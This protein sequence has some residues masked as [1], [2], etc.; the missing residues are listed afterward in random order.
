MQCEINN[1]MCTHD[2]DHETYGN[3]FVKCVLK[4]CQI[5]NGVYTHD[6]D[7]ETHGSEFVKYTVLSNRY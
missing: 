7:Y 2:I 6:L 3:D 5:N 1:D 4:Y